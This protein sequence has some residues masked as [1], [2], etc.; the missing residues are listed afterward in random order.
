MSS[1]IGLDRPLLLSVYCRAPP[2]SDSHFL[3]MYPLAPNYLP[4]QTPVRNLMLSFYL[5]NCLLSTCAEFRL[6]LLVI[7]ISRLLINSACTAEPPKMTFGCS[8]SSLSLFSMSSKAKHS[9]A[10]CC[11]T[12]RSKGLLLG[13][14][15]VVVCEFL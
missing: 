15:L 9:S 2:L 4:A 7:E 6:G 1:E 14:L 10:A 12:W 11:S 5:T 8:W 3:F 13:L